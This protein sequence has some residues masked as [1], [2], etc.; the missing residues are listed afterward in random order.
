MSDPQGSDSTFKSWKELVESLSQELHR[1]ASLFGHPPA[2]IY[3]AAEML[4]FRKAQQVS[5]PKDYVVLKAGKP[6]TPSSHLLC[7]SLEFDAT[8]QVMRVGGQLCRMEGLDS[9][10]VHCI[11]AT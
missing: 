8:H 6:V 1:A 4:A 3:Q 7:L 11:V 2:S 5:F 9:L 10:A